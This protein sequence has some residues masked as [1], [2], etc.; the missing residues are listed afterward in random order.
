M[1]MDP[2]KIYKSMNLTNA[3]IVTL[4]IVSICSSIVIGLGAFILAHNTDMIKLNQEILNKLVKEQTSDID[5]IKENSTYIQ[6]NSEY[7]KRYESIILDTQQ[8]MRIIE[9]GVMSCM[10]CHKMNYQ[11]HHD[12]ELPWNKK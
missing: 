6:I 1:I 9:R 4:L 2:I 11:L 12:K 5:T 10:E 7:L 8:K 3:I